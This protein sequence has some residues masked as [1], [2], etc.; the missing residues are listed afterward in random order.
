[1]T[2]DK[3]HGNFEENPQH[4]YNAQGM[5][6]LAIIA[7]DLTGALDA[8]AAFCCNGVNVVVAVNLDA[9]EK[10]LATNAEVVAVSTASR[11]CPPDIATALV[12]Q[13]VALSGRRTIIKKIDSRLKGHL[14]AELAP[15]A[16][17]QLF[18]APALPSFG[19]YVEGGF[20]KGFGVDKPIDIGRRLGSL[21]LNAAIP[22]C[23][24]TQDIS[25]AL[26]R[27]LQNENQETVL[28]GARGLTFA[29]AKRAGLEPTTPAKLSGKIGMVIGSTDP[30]TVEQFDHLSNTKVTKLLAPSGLF[31]DEI[32][33]SECIA[34]QAT[35]GSI[36]DP[37]EVGKQLAHS[38][39]RVA[40]SCDTL[41]LTG[42][43][44]A[45]AVL[46][47]LGVDMLYMEGELLPGLPISHSNNW[48]V[49]TKSGGFGDVD[50]LA[51]L[52]V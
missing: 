51:R 22:D 35:S 39:A 31:E 48:R 50:T 40:K 23:K 21:A 49:V 1:M 29:L 24:T 4:S 27:H 6:P 9:F 3:F 28:V 33:E 14:S 32:V 8:A 17:K 15:F 52:L 44:T 18:V 7:D 5:F 47:E 20:V 37:I 25:L 30:I 26:D 16:D 11:E 43:A 10:A 46:A 45:E 12:E 2:L 38:F 34:M 13:A 36:S 19:R 42:G 41:V